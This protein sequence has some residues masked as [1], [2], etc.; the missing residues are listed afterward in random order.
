MERRS[1]LL[2]GLVAPFVI[3]TPGLLMKIRTVPV[4][5]MTLPEYFKT[6]NAFHRRAAT[7]MIEQFARSSSVLDDLHFKIV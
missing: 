5:L 2:G 3:T 4:G 1:F 7:D 6:L